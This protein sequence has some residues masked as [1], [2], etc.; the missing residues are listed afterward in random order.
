MSVSFS[1]FIFV[2]LVI[3]FALFC[4]IDICKLL[5]VYVKGVLLNEDLMM[6]MMM[7]T[8]SKIPCSVGIKL[9]ITSIL[10]FTCMIKKC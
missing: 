6:I 2:F 7:M 9:N 4:L 1:I 5:W 8:R 10:G 3:M